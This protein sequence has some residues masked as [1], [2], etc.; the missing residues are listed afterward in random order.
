MKFKNISDT[1]MT[2]RGVDFPVGKTVT[3]EDKSLASKVSAMPEF[4]EVK[5]GR[6]AKADDKD[7][8]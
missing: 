8:S 1:D 7:P 6:K 3:V 2:L 4:E 5:R